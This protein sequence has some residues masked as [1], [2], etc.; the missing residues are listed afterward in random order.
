[1]TSIRMSIEE[2]EAYPREQF[3]HCADVVIR[4]FMLRDETKL[5]LVY[6]DGMTRLQSVEDNIL[7]PLIFSGLPLSKRTNP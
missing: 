2:N 6:L 3:N 4:S 5:I 7:K 1:M